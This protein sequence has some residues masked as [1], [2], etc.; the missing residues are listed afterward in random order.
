MAAPKDILKVLLATPGA[1]YLRQTAKA[2]EE[3]GALAGLWVSDKNCTGLAAGN[4]HRCWAFH[5]LMK[6]FYHCAPQIW[7]ERAFYAFFMSFSAGFYP[8]R[9]RRLRSSRPSWASPPSRS[10]PPIT[11]AL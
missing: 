6:P 3:R 1:W 10:T 9:F 4:Y 2:F 7:T 8:N 5:L 11:A